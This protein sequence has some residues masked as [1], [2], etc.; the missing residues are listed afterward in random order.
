MLYILTALSA[1][2]KPIVEK[3]RLKR[4]YDLPY[5]L[6]ENEHTKL[7]V[8]GIGSENAMMTT[9]ALFGY[10][11]PHPDDLFINVGICAAPA[12]YALGE[13]LL[14]H[15]I[16]YKERFFFSDILFEHSLQESDLTCKDI[17]VDTL[18][19]TPVDMESYG[20]F[21][22]ASRFLD[23][24]QILFFKVVSDHFEPSSVTKELAHE[25]ISKNL[26]KFQEIIS[27]SKSIRVQKE[28]FDIEE[29]K[30]IEAISLSLTLSQSNAF[31]DACCYYKL[32]HKK[33]LHVSSITPPQTKL[34]KLQ[35]SGYLEQLI[36]TLTL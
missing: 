29:K 8:S 25:L 21:T 13:A 32:H 11:K 26:V 5:T 10:A 16:T 30:L 17:A 19:N 27:A 31:Y 18:Q 6:F 24:H 22:A 9:S 2:A 35:R 3:L 7:I 33:P 1:E 36:K 15:K 28:L 12:N 20:V 4:V 14:I 34:S 23:T